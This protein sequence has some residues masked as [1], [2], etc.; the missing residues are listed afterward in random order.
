[1]RSSATYP[2]SARLG[3]L[4]PA[5]QVGI[6]GP[7]TARREEL[8]DTS[9]MGLLPQLIDVLLAF[10]EGQSSL[11]RKIRDAR[12]EYSSD[13]SPAV[14]K[15]PQAGTSRFEPLR[16]IVGTCLNASVEVL[17][18]PR[19]NVDFGIGP[20]LTNGFGNGSL[21]DPRVRV[22]AAP[23]CATPSVAAAPST[24]PAAIVAR[25]D[26]LAELSSKAPV[27]TDEHNSA[28]SAEPTT[29]RLN[30][31]YNFFD[32]LDARLA[33]LQGQKIDPEIGGLAT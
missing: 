20:P 6:G 23:T 32:E 5:D 27:P 17:Q 15:Y 13:S 7:V 8:S 3:G 26:T 10:T 16:S 12:L 14:E 18:A 2:I 33:H 25:R 9:S 28:R 31:D 30:R 11:S 4:L 19:S 22:S 1:M 24:P 21:P 29:A